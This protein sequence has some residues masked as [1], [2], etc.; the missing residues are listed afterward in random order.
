MLQAIGLTKNYGAQ[1]ALDRLD[2]DIQPGDIYALLG[3]NGA[4][5]TTT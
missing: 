1:T 2:L 5:K 4:G 3:A